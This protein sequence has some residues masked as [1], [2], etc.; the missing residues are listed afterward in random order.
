VYLA[1]RKALQEAVSLQLTS[2]GGVRVRLERARSRTA[3]PVERDVESVLLD[4][5]EDFPTLA[6][7]VE[8][9]SGGQRRL[10][11]GRGDGGS[12]AQAE[13]LPSE[14]RS[15]EAVVDREE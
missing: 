4:L 11:M 9:R 10:P 14:S 5:A 3:R 12:P 2:W 6:M 7:L 13:L 15:G 1:Y 8:R